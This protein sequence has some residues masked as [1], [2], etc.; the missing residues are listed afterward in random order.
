MGLIN[1]TPHPID[2]YDFNVPD[3][4]EP[5]THLPITVIKPSG[6]V[7]RVEG[8]EIGQWHLDSQL[9]VINVNYRGVNGLP[10]YAGHM[11]SEDREVWYIVSLPVAL[12]AQRADLLVPYSHVRN[13]TGSVIGCRMLARSV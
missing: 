13:M 12:A 10:P 1:L 8:D 5:D 7:A 9:L 6:E 11:N 4:I 3:Q 2:V